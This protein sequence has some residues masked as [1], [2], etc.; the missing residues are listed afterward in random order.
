MTT[1]NKDNGGQGGIRTHGTLSRTHAFQACAL[2]H[3]ATCPWLLC[4]VSDAKRWNGAIY[5]DDFFW[6]NR[7]LQE[8]CQTPSHHTSLRRKCPKVMHL[9]RAGTSGPDEKSNG[10]GHENRFPHP[11]PCC[12]DRSDPDRH[13]GCDSICLL[14]VRRPHLP[15]EPLAELRRRKPRSGGG[16]YPPLY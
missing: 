15:W 8:K 6:I 11:K 5:T 7:Y 13:A 10:T 3:S 9:G 12:V 4:V 1:E 16:G 2:N 14:V